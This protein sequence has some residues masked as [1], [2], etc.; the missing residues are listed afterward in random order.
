MQRALVLGGATGLL[1][2]AIVA[3]LK[4]TQEWDITTLGRS[5]GDLFSQAF[6][7]QKLEETRPDV[8]FN[9]V[10]WTQVDDAEDHPNE[11][12]L[13]NAEFPKLLA[14]LLLRSSAHLVHF[15][16]DF[17]FGASSAHPLSEEEQPT[18]QSVY[19]RTKRAGEEA[20]L[21]LLPDRAA[22][23]RTA[24]LF[25][26]HRKNFVATIIHAAKSRKELKVVSDQVGSP[27][28]TLDLAEWSIRLAQG[29]QH[30]I[31][32]TVNAD[33]SSWYELAKT[34]VELAELDCQVTPIPSSA[35]PQKAERPAY[36]VLSTDKLSSFLNEKVRSWKSALKDY[37]QAK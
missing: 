6:L 26:P 20:V 36:S 34:A 8:V 19:G 25:G 14:A 30:G 9:T 31:W 2:Q 16:T 32:H 1:G 35:W 22:V 4:Q 27:T 28:Y 3:K 29:R 24:W 15:S 23:L 21:G 33:Q 10:A 37:L 18:P 13:V 11:A 7:T 5:D 17:V 12:H